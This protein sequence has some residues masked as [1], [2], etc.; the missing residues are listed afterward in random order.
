MSISRLM[1]MGAAGVPKIYYKATQDNTDG[2]NSYVDLGANLLPDAY[3]TYTIEAWVRPLITPTG[4]GYIVDQHS[5]TG[6]AGRLL[7]GARNANMGAFSGGWYETSTSFGSTSTFA[8]LAYVA[9]GDGTMEFFKD[10]V[11]AGTSGVYITTAADAQNTL[12]GQDTSFGQF[13]C[14]YRGFRINSTELYTANFTPPSIDGGLTNVSG[15]VALWNGL[16]GSAVDASGNNTWSAT[17]FSF[18]EV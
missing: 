9:K 1:Q 12:W 18:S 4:E 11:S 5:A 2:K 14:E 6:G 15:T 3:P 13:G 8:H 16:S 10:G 17:N 7:V